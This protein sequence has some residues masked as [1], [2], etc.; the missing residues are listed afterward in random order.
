MK[1]VGFG[2][3]GLTV[4]LVVVVALAQSRGGADRGA[5]L[6]PVA[7][8]APHYQNAAMRSVVITGSAQVSRGNGP[9]YVTLESGSIPA[10]VETAT[11]L[12]DENCAPD[13]GG[14]SHCLNRVQFQ[15][16]QGMGEAV[17]RHHHRMSEEPCLSPGETVTI[18]A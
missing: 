17:L 5:Q 6:A 10:G 8:T 4:A 16:A 3:V 15:T 2:L 14:V 13:Q 7:T 12:T 11:V 1:Y 18:A 9:V